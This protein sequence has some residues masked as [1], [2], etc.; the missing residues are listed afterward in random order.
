MA[1]SFQ[2]KAVGLVLLG[3]FLAPLVRAHDPMQCSAVTRLRAEVMEIDMV[4]SGYATQFLLADSANR[5]ALSPEN[6]EDYQAELQQTALGL[7]SV[8]AGGQV[9]IPKVA[10]V[11]LTEEQDIEFLISYPP[12]TV[13]P[14]RLGITFF[15]KMPDGYT[16]SMFVQDR[17]DQNLGWEDLDASKD[18]MEVSLASPTTPAV[19]VRPAAAP[20]T[21]PAQP[22]ALRA[23]LIRRG[24]IDMVTGIGHALFLCGLLAGCRNLRS[25]GPAIVCFTLA[26]SATLALGAFDVLTLPTRL[27]DALIAVS[28]VFVGIENL[29][30][31]GGPG[32]RWVPALAFGLIHGFAFARAFK[33]AAGSGGRATVGPL[34]SFNLGLELGQIALAVVLLTVLWKLRAVP[35]FARLGVPALSSAIAALGAYSLVQHTLFS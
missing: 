15:G 32:A 23:Q 16:L 8:T 4:M 11:E 26:H 19:P 2:Q 14:L 10:T 1:T 18:W 20:A 33:D 34:A 6:F 30:R 28:V 27:V 5:P 31:R 7:F 12:P 24:A 3:L 22:P 35:S 29:A 9:L 13:G 17:R 21:P 25:A